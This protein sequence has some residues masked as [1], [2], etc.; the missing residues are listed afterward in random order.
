MGKT[1]LE[2]LARFQ[3]WLKANL[4]YSSLGLEDT[5]KQEIWGRGFE[6]S[7]RENQHETLGNDKPNSMTSIQKG[8]STPECPGVESHSDEDSGT[9]RSC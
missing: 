1:M 5:A 3:V 2:Y 8:F 4:S 9:A 7:W 6:E